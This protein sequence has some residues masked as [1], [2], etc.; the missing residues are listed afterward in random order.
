MPAMQLTLPWL[1]ALLQGQS[2]EVA[3]HTRFYISSRLAT[4][5]VCVRQGVGPGSTSDPATGSASLGQSSLPGRPAGAT[6]D[7][8]AGTSERPEPTSTP[9]ATVNQDPRDVPARSLA[10]EDG[11]R[12]SSLLGKRQRSPG[13]ES[14]DAAKSSSL[15][16]AGSS[17]GVKRHSQDD[18]DLTAHAVRQQGQQQ[19]QAA[20]HQQRHQPQLP[21]MHS[22]GTANAAEL[23]GKVDAA[24]GARRLDPSITSPFYLLAVR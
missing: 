5:S 6:A 16:G 10:A 17:P 11:A 14:G 2:C 8:A 15:P 24:G 22:S 19:G 13:P 23:A 1:T 20:S 9:G 18:P 3:A 12:P 21:A 7:A 4:T